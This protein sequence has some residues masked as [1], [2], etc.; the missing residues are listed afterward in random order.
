MPSTK[1]LN[2]PLMTAKQKINT[3]ADE[4]RTWG[5]VAVVG[6]GAS[7]M[8]GFPLSKQL[9]NLIW[10]AIDSN[11]NAHSDL[12]KRFKKSNK[13]AKEL[14]GDDPARI[15][16]AYKAPLERHSEARRVFQDG[17]ASLDHA[18]RGHISQTH[19]SLAELIHRGIVELTVCL[20]WDTLLESAY[21]L[22]YGVA[23]ARKSELLFKPHGSADRPDLP[24]V[25]PHQSGL[26]PS[27]LLSRV[28]E[29]ARLR[30]RVLLVI[31]YSERDEEVVQKFDRT[32]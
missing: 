7:L 27:N 16:L 4:I 5:A 8:S 3:A 11:P 2:V 6:A 28:S 23:L 20:N 22:K 12:S 30:P 32:A 31:G 24:W 25:L 19:G 10:T 14:I 9:T 21:E 1:P 15:Q 17:F 29:L 13:S 18:R 26:V